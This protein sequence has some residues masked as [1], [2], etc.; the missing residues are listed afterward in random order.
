MKIV[1]T[2]TMPDGTVVVYVDN[3][4]VIIRLLKT[5]YDSMGLA[6]K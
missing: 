2:E 1:N 4:G 6:N 3:Q 5:T